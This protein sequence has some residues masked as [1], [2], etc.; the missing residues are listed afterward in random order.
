MSKGTLFIISAPSGAGKSSLIRRI[1]TE[2]EDCIFSVSYTTRPARGRE[3]HGI[4][5][6]FINESEFINMIEENLFLE[7]AKVH[8]YYYGTGKEYILKNLDNGKNV[9]LDID[10]QGARIVK[11]NLSG[12]KYDI[13]SIFIM[14]P[15]YSELKNRLEK[16]A[17]DREDTISTRLKNAIVEME[18]ALFYDYVI[19]NRVFKDAYFDLSSIFRSNSLKTDN[20]KHKIDKIIKKYKEELH[21][22]SNN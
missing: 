11:S 13:V 16:R 8:D 19:I 2:R 12:K 18:N 9:I 7:Y 1:L 15:S 6:F 10:Y 14:P 5:Y 22:T 3:R 17:T 4:E 20:L 21:G